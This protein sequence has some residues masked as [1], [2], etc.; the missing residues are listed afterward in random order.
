MTSTTSYLYVPMPGIGGICTPR[1]VNLT[2]SGTFTC[3]VI[4]TIENCAYLNVPYAGTSSICLNGACSSNS[5]TYT[6]NSSVL[7]G[8]SACQ[9]IVTG[10]SLSGTLSYSSGSYSIQSPPVISTST[11]PS[12]SLNTEYAVTV[13][14]NLASANTV[15]S[16][17]PG[18]LQG[19]SITMVGGI[20]NILNSATGNCATSAGVLTDVPFAVDRTFSCPSPS[21]CSNSYYIDTLGNLSLTINK[22]ASQSIEAITASSNISLG[23]KAETYTLNILYSSDGWVLDPQYYIVAASLTASPTADGTDPTTKYLSLKWTFVDSSTVSNPP[24]NNFYSYFSYLWTP[25]KQKFGMN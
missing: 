21:P 14:I 25:L 2:T 12:A 3:R 20:G 18:Y 22:Y 9:Y 23:C 5:S 7:S 19:K 15:R 17:N 16:G 11:N 24:S 4:P 8:T 10:F 1:L 13:S 6:F